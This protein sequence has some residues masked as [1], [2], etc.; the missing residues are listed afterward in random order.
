MYKHPRFAI[1]L[2]FDQKLDARLFGLISYFNYQIVIAPVP[3]YEFLRLGDP[4]L[5]LLAYQYQRAH[6]V[7]DAKVDQFF[8]VHMDPVA[9]VPVLLLVKGAHGLQFSLG[10]LARFG[11]G[12]SFL[13]P[14]SGC[15]YG[16]PTVYKFLPAAN[17]ELVVA[18]F[19]Y[20]GIFKGKGGLRDHFGP[21]M[22]LFLFDLKDR[23]PEDLPVPQFDMGGTELGLPGHDPFQ[24]FFLVGKVLSEIGAERDLEQAEAE[25]ILPIVI[26]Q[27]TDQLHAER[28]GHVPFEILEGAFAPPVF[29]PVLV[30]GTYEGVVECRQ[31]VGWD[32][33]LEAV[34]DHA[35]GGVDTGALQ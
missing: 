8:A 19:D 21:Q 10:P 33:P 26:M 4:D 35:I 20:N 16:Q 13:C 14:S 32:L 3:K 12:G 15:L 18:R 2:S 34:R 6:L 1:S 11:K 23:E 9:Y 27:P 5:V 22:M 7:L 29:R 24:Q 25:G 28:K 17:G 30:E 31:Y